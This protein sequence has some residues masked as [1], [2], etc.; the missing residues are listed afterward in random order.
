[1]KFADTPTAARYLFNWPSICITA[2]R[3]SLVHGFSRLSHHSILA[4]VPARWLLDSSDHCHD[5][6]DDNILLTLKKLLRSLVFAGPGSCIW[7]ARNCSQCSGV[8]AVLANLG[9]ANDQ[10]IT[11]LNIY[12]SRYENGNNLDFGFSARNG[13]WHVSGMFIQWQ[14]QSWLIAKC[15][16]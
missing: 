15:G 7:F 3:F 16:W 2:R 1:M 11:G 13:R 4:I 8:L 10:R 14:L 6:R 5:F 12:N 9:F